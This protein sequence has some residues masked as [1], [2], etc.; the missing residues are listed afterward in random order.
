MRVRL[1]M[2][3]KGWKVIEQVRMEGFMMLSVDLHRD[4]AVSGLSDAKVAWYSL[5]V[6]RVTG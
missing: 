4:W 3:M 5:G 1:R 6:D 2:R